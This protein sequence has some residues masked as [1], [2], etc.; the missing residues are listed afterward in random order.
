MTFLARFSCNL[1]ILGV[2]NATFFPHIKKYWGCYSTP[3]TPTSYNLAILSYDI[4]ARAGGTGG[5]GGAIAPPIFL[6]IGEK[7]AFST[8]NISRLVLNAPQ[9]VISTPNISH[10]PMS[11]NHIVANQ[12]C[13]KRYFNYLQSSFYKY[14]CHQIP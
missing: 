11:L 3:S 8:P 6:K 12:K 1:E 5:A 4:L 2:L 14:A 7:V 13:P 10:L 9:K